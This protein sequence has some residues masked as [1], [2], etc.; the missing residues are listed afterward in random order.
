MECANP[1]QV[2]MQL[3]FNKPMIEVGKFLRHSNPNLS[4]SCSRFRSKCLTNEFL[5]ENPRLG[6]Q[7]GRF[8]RVEKVSRQ[9]FAESTNRQV[10]RDV[11]VN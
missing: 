3:T 10:C 1:E 6:T 11:Q 7:A 4:Q 5:T 8:V 2:N 9:R